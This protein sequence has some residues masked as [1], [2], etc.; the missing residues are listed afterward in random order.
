MIRSVLVLGGGSA[1]L[2]AAITLKSRLPQL[3]VTVL[4]PKDRGDLWDG[5]GTTP[6]LGF[7]LHHYCKLDVPT[8]YHL[9]QPQ[10]KLGIRFEWGP[11]PFFNY[12]FGFELDTQYGLLPR[13]TGYYVN[14]TEAFEATGNQTGLM[15]ANKVWLRQPDG[16]PRLSADEFGHHLRNDLLVSY[17]QSVAQ[18]LG[19]TI[20]DDEAVEVMRADYGVAGLRTAAHGTLT[21]ELFVDAS[22]LRSQLLGETVKEPFISYHDALYCDRAVVGSWDRAEEPIKPYTTAQTMAAGWCW[23]LEH[24]KRID[25]GY[26]YSS[27][28]LSAGEAEAEFRAN[29]PKVKDTRTVSFRQGRHE[30]FW[31]NNVVGIGDAAAFVDPLEATGLAAA[32]V[33]AQMLAETLADCELQPNPSTI[34]NFNRLHARSTDSV[35]DFLAVHY[36][37]NSRMDTPFWRECR[38]QV[39]LH[40]AEAIVEYFQANGPSVLARRCLLDQAGLQE[41]GME[42]Y[43]ALLVGQSVPYRRPYTP[44]DLDLHNWA[45]IQ[46]SVRNK[47]AGA[48][49]VPEALAMVRS[50]YWAWPERLFNRSMAERP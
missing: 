19:I 5:E 38:G 1:G 24:E 42:G 30:R 3:P 26:V 46:Q 9:A 6:T 12:V 25:R 47:V 23:Q 49:T 33:Q 7:H 50:P 18:Q 48:Y 32:C 29:N 45:R 36:R 20:I 27:S 40:G 2:L 14:D 4:R 43:L 39:A 37:F 34:F 15:N 16:F 31:V 10:W 13:G 21:A 44:S 35:R 17:L 8:F 22:G 41:Y 28:F 11:R